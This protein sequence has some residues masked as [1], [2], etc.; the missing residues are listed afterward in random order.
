MGNWTKEQVAATIDHAALKPQMTDDDIRANVEIGL[1]I[2]E[3]GRT[4]QVVPL[5]LG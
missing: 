4:G 1:A 2:V 3:S 5:P